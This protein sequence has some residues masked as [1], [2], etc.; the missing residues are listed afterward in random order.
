MADKRRDYKTNTFN[1]ELLQCAALCY[2]LNKP[3]ATNGDFFEYLDNFAENKDPD[4]V[5]GSFHA[6]Y[7]IATNLGVFHNEKESA[8]EWVRSSIDIARFLIAKLR[9][10]S[11]HEVH[12]QKSKFGSLI[13]DH[14]LKKISEELGTSEISSKPD[15]YNPTD[16][17]IVD[18]TS[19]KQIRK[20]LGT[21]IISKK[22]NIVANY[23]ANRHTY[24]SI[25]NGYYSK[26]KLY[27]ISLKKSKTA[28]LVTDQT[29]L[30][31][32]NGS[33]GVGYKIIGSTMRLQQRIR[34]IDPYTR[35]LLAFDN[36]LQDG[37]ATKIMKFI[38]DLVDVKKLNYKDEVLQPNLIFE[39]N[40]ENVSIP[41]ANVEKWKLD[42]PGDTFNMQKIGGTAWSGGLNTNGIHQILQNYPKYNPVFREMQRLRVSSYKSVRTNGPVDPNTISTLNKNEIIYK[43]GDLKTIKDG[44]ENTNLYIE[45]LV[46]SIHRL[47]RPY[48]GEKALYGINDK[49]ILTLTRK[50]DTGKS[51]T[52]N[53]KETELKRT[54][55]NL[56]RGQIAFPINI[57][58]CKKGDTNI[59][60]TIS[61]KVLDNKVKKGFYI[62]FI[63][64]NGKLE[65]GTKIESINDKEKTITLSLPVKTG[66][67]N[68]RAYILNPFMTNV[69]SK[70]ELRNIK[71]S[72]SKTIKYLE[73]KY[74]K[75]QCFYMFMRGG[76]RLLNEVL[77]KQIILTIYGL[78]SKK[79]GKLFD[80]SLTKQV[81]D[82][83]FARNA[84]N[85]F[86][87]APFIIVGD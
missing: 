78:V 36:V 82:K 17:W 21:H 23:A 22:A 59:T 56:K 62:F 51:I 32:K 16:I 9:L 33:S 53:G 74:S 3:N 48:R 5:L 40:Y 35:F 69:V 24:K 49:E 14:C 86:I 65:I 28:K 87:I 11:S 44:F 43:T 54:I 2:F 45:F 41:Y 71:G 58:K 8:R 6:D 4:N 19:E 47:T 26:G 12:H 1:Q 20:D 80:P 34:D 13:K 83:F 60:Y 46:E 29:Y 55:S 81:K 85:D 75:V 66:G 61:S 67:S 31:S 25:I 37:N 15:V 64:K 27:Q 52:V 42:T 63:S 10:K 50:I 70:Q 57:P 39:L 18:K 77:K 7:H 72:E 38:E 73:E 30:G 68:I 79:G 84:M 76:K